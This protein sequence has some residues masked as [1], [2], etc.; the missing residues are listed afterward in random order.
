LWMGVPVITLAGNRHGGRVGASLLTHVNLPRLIA[1]SEQ[2]YIDLATS[3]ARDHEQLRSLRQKLR[4]QVTQSSLCNETGF[5][6][7]IE[8]VYRQIWVRRCTIDR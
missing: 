3:L 8:E 1:S 6:R 5:T 2:S 4:D 7:S